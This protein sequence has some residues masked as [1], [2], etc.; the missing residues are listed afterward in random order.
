[1]SEV[2]SKRITV[3]GLDIHYF[4][5]GT[6]D[7]LIIIHGGSGGASYWTETIKV[8]SGSYTVY[9]PDMP[10][11]G[12]SQAAEGTYYIPEMVNFVD[13]FAH[14]IG[15][16]SFNLMGHSLG[17]G[18]ALHYINKYPHKIRKLVL[19]SSLCLGKEI[20]WWIRLV[21]TPVLC[22]VISKTVNSLFKG[23]QNLVK[24]F[25]PW[26]IIEPI[27]KTSVQIGCGITGFR[28][29]NMVMLES[30]HKIRIPTLVM[31]GENDPIVPFR[32]AY[33]AADLIPDCQVKVF[34]NTGHSVYS[35]RLPEFTTILSAFLE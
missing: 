27:S 9:V 25:G 10:G 12:T 13:D 33:A 7:P 22:R 17:G 31:W 23:I 11:F 28:Q 2:Q 6:G 5:G 1:M 3:N 29:Q 30:L 34:A 15:H 24:Y 18:I 20:A 35:Q 4:T 16:S 26:K 32:Q 21:S 19:V 8:L 14:A